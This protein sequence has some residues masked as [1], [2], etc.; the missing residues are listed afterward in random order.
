MDIRLRDFIEGIEASR[1]RNFADA[2]PWTLTSRAPEIVQSL[3]V[4][5]GD[6]FHCRDGVAIHRTASLEPGVVVKGPAIIGAGC[7]LAGGAYLRGGVWLDENCILG[8]GVELKSSIL[9]QDVRLAHF[10]FVG[11]SVLGAGIN[12][13]AGSIVANFRNERDEKRIHIHVNGRRIDTG[14]EKFGALIGDGVRIGANAVL[15]PGS[16][17][18]PG[19]VV[20]RLALVDQDS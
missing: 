20:A 17:L 1:L 13:E 5:I 9:S 8:P 4:D 16:I 14:V 15:A 6:D 18:K 2:Q 19:M 7:R 3:L 12:L 10:N 11:D